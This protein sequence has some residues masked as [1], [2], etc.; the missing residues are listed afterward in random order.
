VILSHVKGD[1]R[2]KAIIYKTL[3]AIMEVTDVD[4][5]NDK[6][7]QFLAAGKEDYK[8][9]DFANYFEREYAMRPHL[10]A[11]CHPL[12]LNPLLPRW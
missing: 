4:K 8:T 7:S 10:W 6:I 12:G 11:Y 2:L 1:S 9:S 3:R 5:F